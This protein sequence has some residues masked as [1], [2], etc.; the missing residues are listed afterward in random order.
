MS[1]SLY[2]IIER[3]HD[4]LDNVYRESCALISSKVIT[5]TPVDTGL[6]RHSWTPSKGNPDFSNVGGSVAEVCNSLQ[7]GET[8]SLGNGQPYVRRIEYEG[9]SPQA[10]DGMMRRSIAEWQQFVDEAVRGS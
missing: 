2:A 6:L 8:Y 10:P 4:K 9:H 3:Y 5:R 7:I 1:E